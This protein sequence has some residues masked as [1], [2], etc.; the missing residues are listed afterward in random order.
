MTG[1]VNSIGIGPVLTGNGRTG[2]VYYFDFITDAGETERVSVK[3]KSR[4]LD[5]AAK[6]EAFNRRMRLIEQNRPGIVVVHDEASWD[7]LLSL[8]STI[9][10]RRSIQAGASPR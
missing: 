9:G 10:V 3:K 7:G 1:E 8:L 4:R 2:C 5:R 6:V